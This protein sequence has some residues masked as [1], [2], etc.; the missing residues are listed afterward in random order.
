VHSEHHRRGDSV[1]LL[2]P[3]ELPGTGYGSEVE[4]R[5]ERV[6]FACRFMTFLG[7]GGLLLGSV[8]CFLKVFSRF[9]D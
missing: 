2:R 3:V 5:I 4:A 9:I 7:I 6:I 1:V 8:P